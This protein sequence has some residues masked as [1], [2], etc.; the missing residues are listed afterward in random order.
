MRQDGAVDEFIKMKGMCMY[1]HFILL[2]TY[3]HTYAID[4]FNDAHGDVMY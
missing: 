4:D 2:D 1:I 3:K